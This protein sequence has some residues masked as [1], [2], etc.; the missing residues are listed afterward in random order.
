MKYTPWFD[1]SVKPVRNGV[2]QRIYDE[3]TRNESVEHC[4][5]SRGVWHVCARRAEDAEK[6]EACSGLQELKWRGLKTK[7]GK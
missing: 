4:K 2:Y 3:G 5:F 7:D 1:G 6:H